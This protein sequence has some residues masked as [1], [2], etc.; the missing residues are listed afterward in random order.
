[1]YDIIIVGGG[2]AGLSLAYQCKKSFKIL[3][4]EKNDF[5]SGTTSQSLE[6]FSQ[7]YSPELFSPYLQSCSDFYINLHQDILRKR[8]RLLLHQ[9][10]VDPGMTKRYQRLGFEHL[11]DLSQ[12]QDRISCNEL[13]L[14]F[15]FKSISELY[16]EENYFDLDMFCLKKSLIG[17]SCFLKLS[18][19]S[20]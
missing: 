14:F 20:F 15:N 7:A 4:L 10:S 6:G 8:G 12:M 5:F 17:L 9:D 3:V 1:M 2:I 19:S 13:P 11:A 16:Y 18:S